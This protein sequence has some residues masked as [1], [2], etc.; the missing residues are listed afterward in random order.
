[1]NT[2][3]NRRLSPAERD[4]L[5]RKSQ[6]KRPSKPKFTFHS[7]EDAP[8]G[9]TFNRLGD[10]Y[11]ISF[12]VFH[13]VKTVFFL[14]FSLGALA[15]VFFGQGAEFENQGFFLVFTLL[16]FMVMFGFFIKQVTRRT[17]IT[18]ANGHLGVSLGLFH[19]GSKESMPVTE[20]RRI[21]KRFKKI[22]YSEYTPVVAG[23]VA[24]EDL[25]QNVDTRMYELIFYGPSEVSSGIIYK[26]QHADY[27]RYAVEQYAQQWR[28][29]Q[30]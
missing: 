23:M 12:S 18:L 22:G 26:E 11:E 14:L 9:V 29:N 16:L 5:R 15:L 10:G 7:V 13:W 4:R 20:L 27:I 25:G 21:G 1:M 2:K 24:P 17:T 19:F 3:H 28:T 30:R 8:S 6:S